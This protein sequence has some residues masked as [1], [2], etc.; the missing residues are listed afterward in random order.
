MKKMFYIAAIMLLTIGMVSCNKE[1]DTTNNN[2]NTP[3][4]GTNPG[5]DPG[6][7]PSVPDGYVDLGLPSGL[8]WAKCNVGATAPEEFGNYY[9]WGEVSTKDNYEWSTYIYAN[10]SERTLTKYNTSADYGTVD[11]K[12]TLE[13]ADDAAHVELGDGAR[14]PTY[15]EW[16]ELISGTTSEMTR[17]NEVYGRKFTSKTNGKTIF[18]PTAGY[19]YQTGTFDQNGI[20]IYWSSSLDLDHPYSAKSYRFYT[21]VSDM[22]YRDRYYGH[23]VRAVRP[24]R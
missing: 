23:S 22:S 8:L 19:K 20:G 1:E 2:T 9:A 14:I 4:G 3:S 13:Y 24:L 21:S 17:E 5:T 6:T 18:I 16:E 10:G 15:E 12:K 11:G 7:T